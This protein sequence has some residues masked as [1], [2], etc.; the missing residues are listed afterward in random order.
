LWFDAGGSHGGFKSELAEHNRGIAGD[1]DAG[2][3]FA[4]HFC[5]FENKRFDPLMTQCN[6]SSQSA[7]ATTGNQYAHGS[8]PP[9]DKL[10]DFA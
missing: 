1:L 4:Q 6:R 3:D 9:L 2:T 5:L 7:D 10:S 8:S